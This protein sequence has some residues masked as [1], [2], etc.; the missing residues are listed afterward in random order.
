[1][2]EEHAKMSSE[3]RQLAQT[4]VT[5]LSPLVQAAS[6]SASAGAG[7][8][9]GKCEQVW[10]PVCAVAAVAAGEPHPLAALIAEHSVALL[11]LIRDMATQS[12]TDT[13]DD[14]RGAAASTVPPPPA[15]GTYQPIP[16][17]VFE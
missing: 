10:C 3:L 16:V 14:E 13:P 17:T 4:L 8:G 7:D 11:A 5:I 15:P 6:A 9:A 1:M 2:A 12:P